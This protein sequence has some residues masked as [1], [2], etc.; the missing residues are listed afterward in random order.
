MLAGLIIFYGCSGERRGFVKN[1]VDDI[2]KTNSDLKNYSIILFDMNYD[3]NKDVY[4]HQYQV[5]YQPL[6]NADTLISSTTDWLAV[7]DEYFLKHQ[8]DMGM[9]IVTKKDGIVSKVTSPA[10]YSQYVGNEKY[11]EWRQDNSGHSFWHFYGQYAFMSSLFHMA[12]FPVRYSY[13]N[14]YYGNYYGRGRSYY[15]R[16]ADGRP[17]YGTNSRHNSTTRSNSSWNNKSSSFKQNVRNRV[18]QSSSRRS[19][20]SSRYRGSRSRSRGGGFGK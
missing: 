20:S 13:W 18:K 5:L 4:Q 15:G 7:S 12:M 3:E 11:G 2:I 1:P 16:S 8:E 19:R 14:D 17:L 6:N 10:G 9:E